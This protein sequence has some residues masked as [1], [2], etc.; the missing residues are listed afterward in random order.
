MH[1]NSKLRP[2]SVCHGV[3][4]SMA[5]LDQRSACKRQSA[6]SEVL[7]RQCLL[8][9]WQGNIYPF[10]VTAHNSKNQTF[11]FWEIT[12]IHMQAKSNQHIYSSI[13]HVY[14]WFMVTSSNSETLFG[15]WHV[16]QGQSRDMTK[17]IRTKKHDILIQNIS[18][19]KGDT[20]ALTIFNK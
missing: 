16:L 4:I 14:S 1:S 7:T 9:D 12:R 17:V 11:T 8:L 19:L 13:S 2:Q 6:G 3:S 20:L 5:C 15:L 10:Q 18:T